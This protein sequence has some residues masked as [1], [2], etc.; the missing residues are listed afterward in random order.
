MLQIVLEERG[1]DLAGLIVLAK[2]GVAVDIAEQPGAQL[3][4]RPIHPFGE[5]DLPALLRGGDHVPHQRVYPD[6]H[7]LAENLYRFLRQVPNGDNAGPQ[8]V[9]YVVVDVRY[10]VGDADDLPLPRGGGALPRVVQNAVPDLQGQV[11]S[12]PPFLQ[13][14]HDA[15]GVLVVAETSSV[16][17]Q[18]AREG[19]FPGV[20]ERG[21]P[22]VV[23]EGYG[24]GEV[25]VET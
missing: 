2:S 20:A 17:R 8:G 5:G 18:H 3:H 10:A 19:L 4:E 9:V 11:Y 16:G 25:L 24:L 1:H 22:Q 23:A 6:A 15:E 14:V 12:L 21:M 7:L 13:M